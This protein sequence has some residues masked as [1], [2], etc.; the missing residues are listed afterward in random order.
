MRTIQFIVIFLL[1]ATPS[2]GLAQSFVIE[3]EEEMQFQ[4]PQG[5]EVAREFYI[6]NI[7]HE[8]IWLGWEIVSNTIPSSWD[9]SLC[10]NR[11][12]YNTVPASAYMEPIDSASFGF[13]R[14]T[15]WNTTSGSGE[16]VVR[17]F[18]EHSSESKL[19]T[20]RV[21]HAN[22]AEKISGKL[23]GIY[24]NPAESGKSVSVENPGSNARKLELFD[25]FGQRVFVTDIQVT[26]KSK[27]TLPWLSSGL[28][29]AQFL[30]DKGQK[31][32]TQ[33]VI[34]R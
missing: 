19:I 20:Y 30:D 3:P 25:S 2:L 13:M 29:F 34:V 26:A 5:A 17:I 1:L 31:I 8:A 16:L 32:V 9:Y 21:E 10:D 23:P 24:P 18:N 22:P 6:T 11:I 33:K 27:F 4:I 12:C 7:H 28:Y 15:L 14:L